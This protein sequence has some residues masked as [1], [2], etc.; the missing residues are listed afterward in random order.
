MC[1]ARTA[2]LDRT[3]RWGIVSGREIESA[4]K[5]GLCLRMNALWVPCG[6]VN[7]FYPT[8]MGHCQCDQCGLRGRVN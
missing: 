7:N 3:E 4:E 1:P 2:A 6:R 8:V 5:L